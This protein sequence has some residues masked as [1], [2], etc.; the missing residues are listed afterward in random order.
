MSL[1]S[2]PTEPQQGTTKRSK[3]PVT[4]TAQEQLLLPDR[5]RTPVVSA[6]NSIC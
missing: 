1:E 5:L 6:E 3:G 2:Q 4:A